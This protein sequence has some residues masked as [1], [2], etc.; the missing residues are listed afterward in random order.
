MI[1]TH[2]TSRRRVDFVVIAVLACAVLGGCATMKQ[3]VPWGKSDTVS[4]AT[5][6]SHDDVGTTSAADGTKKLP[7]ANGVDSTSRESKPR[8]PTS[9]IDLSV[10]RAQRDQA[11]PS[12]QSPSEMGTA[13]RSRND[14]EAAIPSTSKLA[15]SKSDVSAGAGDWGRAVQEAIHHRWVQP[16]GPK[17][18]TEFSCDVMVKLTPFGGVD[19]VKVVRSCG[20]VAL[21]ASIE[22]AVRDSSPLPTPKDPAD[23][24][25]TL[26]LTFTPR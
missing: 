3:L 8:R 15:G 7:P 21:D 2:M 24:S 5:N 19:D 9:P 12:G 18:P 11:V 16:R 1:A 14:T 13:D 26:L 23:F 17:I 20:D 10:P 6:E 25:D 22:T 4:T